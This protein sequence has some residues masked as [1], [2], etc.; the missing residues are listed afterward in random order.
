VALIVGPSLAG[1]L[2]A[3]FSPAL[4]I[5]FDAISYLLSALSLLLIARA[6]NTARKQSTVCGSL[7]RKTFAD[8]GEG[9]RF[10]LRQPLVRTMTLLGFGNSFT[11]GAVTSLLVVLACSLHLERWG[12]SVP[13][14]FY[15]I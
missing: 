7:V 13:A 12:L 9:L 5:S 4:A 8:I 11:G 6:F 10:L 2:A 14:L 15:H 1:V 3:A